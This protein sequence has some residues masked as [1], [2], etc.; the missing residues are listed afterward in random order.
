M[1]RDWAGKEGQ[2]E[3]EVKGLEGPWFWLG[4]YGWDKLAWGCEARCPWTVLLTRGLCG[5]RTAPR[6]EEMQHYMQQ[7]DLG[8]PQEAS[9]QLPP[10][11][12]VLR[13]TRHHV[14]T[15]LSA[16]AFLSGPGDG[17]RPLLIYVR[18]LPLPP[19]AW[20]RASCSWPAGP[21]ADHMTKVRRGFLHGLW[22]KAATKGGNFSWA[23][24][25]SMQRSNLLDVM[26]W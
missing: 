4:W 21:L 1:V 16:S 11:S 14:G 24:V 13:Q 18:I 8:D 5:L 22:L 2:G 7:H 20:P 25:C 6:C 15:A 23:K 10:K 3:T 17:P 12:I 9:N 26:G 19:G